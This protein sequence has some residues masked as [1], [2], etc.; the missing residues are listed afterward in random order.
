MKVRDI[1]TSEVAAARPESSLAEAALA[2]WQ[3]DCGSVPV[4]NGA[5]V[6]V[7]M[8]TDRDI[9]MAVAF[10]ERA[11]AEITIG[12]IVRG[13]VYSCQPDM[14]V[15]DAL[16]IMSEQTLRRLPVVDEAGALCGILSLNDVI[17]N[18][19][20]G[21]SKKRKHISHKEIMQTLKAI[22]QHRNAGQESQHASEDA[23]GAVAT[24]DETDSERETSILRS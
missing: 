2:M 12:E 15:E 14:D 21:E 9:C 3:H 16:Q 10:N 8:I 7:G 19:K 17:L 13:K 20:R 22:N 5:G 24:S 23:T 4:V 1:M 18:S 11:A 6:I